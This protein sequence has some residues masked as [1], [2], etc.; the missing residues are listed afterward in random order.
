MNEAQVRELLRGSGDRVGVGPV[1]HGGIAR[2]ARRHRGRVAAAA[3]ATIVAVA[4]MGAGVAQPWAS[5]PDQRDRG[6]DGVDVASTDSLGISEGMRLLGINGVAVEVPESW[7]VIDYVCGG[8]DEDYVYYSSDLRATARCPVLSRRDVS[9]VGIGAIDS[10]VGRWATR[11]MEPAGLVSGL[12]VMEKGEVCRSSLP[13][14]CTLRFAVPEAG[15]FFEVS[16]KGPGGEHLLET[17]RSSLRV[18]PEG[19]TTVPFDPNTTT[20]QRIEAL[21]QAGF[22]VDVVEVYRPELDSGV[23]LSTE[24][25]LGSAIPDGGRVTVLVSGATETTPGSTD[26]EADRTLSTDEFSLAVRTAE[27]AQSKVTGTFVGATAVARGTPGLGKQGCTDTRLIRIRI[28]WKADASFYHG[29]VP[30]GPPDGPRKAQLITINAATGDI[31]R[32][33]ASYRNVGASSGET[34]LYGS[35]P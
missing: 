23:F 24:P 15:V 3:A 8:P 27:E 30:G 19:I 17:I 22:E 11:G 20:E 31:C 28:V 26:T 14:Q 34:L 5:G 6:S 2:R 9:S 16:V 4:L 33:G 21:R 1:P 25:G 35:R 10:I 29:G 12:T 7:P 13:G 18:L 32:Q